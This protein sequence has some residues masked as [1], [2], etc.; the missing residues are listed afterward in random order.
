MSQGIGVQPERV[1]Q[2]VKGID[3][4]ALS[5]QALGTLRRRGVCRYM[6]WRDLQSIGVLAIVEHGSDS[7]ALCVRVARCAMMHAL[8]ANR[9]RERGR[10]QVKKGHAFESAGVDVSEWEM[11]DTT[12]YGGASLVPTKTEPEVWE[13]V[14]ALPEREYRVVM[15]YFWGHKTQAEIGALLGISERHAGRII[16][17][18]IK[19]LREGLQNRK[20]QTITNMRGKGTKG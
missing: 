2:A 3:A 4:A 20:P 19:N 10:V 16:E 11:W 6:D 5:R 9:V 18:A 14:R 7:E 12:I 8:D 13:A 17:A 15:L 1:L